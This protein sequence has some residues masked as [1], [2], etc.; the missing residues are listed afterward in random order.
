MSENRELALVLKLVADQ[1]QSELKKS[2][3]ALAGFN[4]FIKDWK[5]QLSAISGVLVAVAKS[6]ANYGD[7]LF[8]TSQK[9]GIGV[10]ALAGLQYAAKLAD[11]DN[12]QLAQG[13]KFLSTN[14]VEASQRAG[15]GEALFRALGVS[16]VD[17]T[18]R[19]RPTE[20]VLLD[21]AEAFAA[22]ADG[23]AKTETAVK[24]FG[25]AGM[26]MVPFLNA[27]KTG[28]IELMNEARRLGL[29]MSEEN[30][31]AAE[32]FNDELTRL[33]EALNG[34]KLSVGTA[35]I[36]AMTSG[37]EA[38]VGMIE[39]MRLLNDETTNVGQNLKNWSDAFGQTRMGQG[40]MDT[41][42][43]LGFGHRKHEGILPREQFR[44]DLMKSGGGLQGQAPGSGVLAQPDGGGE[45]P[46]MRVLADQEK[47]GKALLEIHLAKNRALDIEN[48]LRTEGADLFPLQTDRQIQREQED[49]AF[50]ERQGKAIV[51]QTLL[52]VRIRDAARSK[53]LQGLTENLKAWQTY[54][55]QVGASQ[56]FL[57][58]KRLDL[59]R[60]ELAQELDTTTDTAG[61]ALLAW[62]NSD[63]DALESL[64]LRLGKT[65]Q[66]L[67]TSLLKAQTTYRRA[68]NE[69]SG[70]FVEGWAEGMRRYVRD[71][72]S[73]F[74]LAADMAR[75]SVQMME[76]SAGRFFFDA[77]EGRITRLKDVMTA[78]LDFT[79]QI[80]S[81][82][83]G[84]AIT[85]QIAGA[86]VGVYPNLFGSS[87]VNT[88]FSGDIFKPLGAA[89]GG[90][91]QRFASGGPVLGAGNLDTV[92]ALLTPGEFVLSRRD[93]GDIKS[94]LGATVVINTYNTS[95]AK[96]EQQVSRRS[97]G[98][99]VVTQTIKDVVAGLVGSGGL[100]GP[101]R[102]RYGVTPSP[103][104]R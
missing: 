2:Q 40:M 25:K 26:E 34:L 98:A 23:A 101:F 85:R 62:Q 11:L 42:T 81:Q 4:S 51:E 17:A 87:G 71:T 52:E 30:A 86:M 73:G 70:D 89:T 29:V 24:L 69:L 84:Q 66:E 15:D 47:L 96:V 9:V 33:Q 31:Q 43:A 32:K 10:E 12:Q 21:V 7:E 53:E 90:T 79:K 5:T 82:L 99:T 67:E 50:Q 8:K 20:Q 54:G 16:A 58:A 13:L 1:F 88:N 68:I 6:T 93:V 97:D 41:F 104:R 94:G 80:V 44:F 28:I 46:Q 100:D 55:E 38:L 18:G 74:G 61:R 83:A 60:A 59:V 91:I 78:F 103:A 92:P 27:G 77:M 35:L 95:S 76:Q 14:M 48:K 19:L 56:E 49:E 75:R 22:H 37:T 39:K 45:K 63:A 72:Q 64:R 65:D 57:L 102:Q 36:P 3:G